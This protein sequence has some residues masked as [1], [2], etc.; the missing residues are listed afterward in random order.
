MASCEATSIYGNCVEER[1]EPS[2]SPTSSWIPSSWCNHG[3]DLAERKWS[4]TGPYH[5]YLPVD[6]VSRLWRRL[7]LCRNGTVRRSGPRLWECSPWLSSHRRSQR[8]WHSEPRLNSVV[9]IPSRSCGWES[10]YDRYEYLP[11]HH[12]KSTDAWPSENREHHRSWSRSGWYNERNEDVSVSNCASICSIVPANEER[13]RSDDER[14]RTNA[15][16]RRD[17]L[18]TASTL[19]LATATFGG[20]LVFDCVGEE[21]AEQSVLRF[22]EQTRTRNTL[23]RR[24]V[25][26]LVRWDLHSGVDGILVLFEPWRGCVRDCTSVVMDIEVRFGFAFAGLGFAELRMFAQ[27]VVVEFLHEGL[28]GRF[29]NDT[30][31]FKNGKDTHGL[32]QQRLPDV[33]RPKIFTFSIRS[34]QAC[35]SIPK[36]MNSHWMPSFLYS[37]CSKTNMWWLKNCWRRSLV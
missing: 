27:M 9:W 19:L 3:F 6:R 21:M 23:T 37:S 5:A 30:F 31:F 28:I 8:E 2:V 25:S 22:T 24:Q 36:S 18:H 33:H 7:S 1:T 15:V 32:E 29:G 26:V 12:C 35:K 4:S 14:T 17:G 34:I 10:L 13:S 16:S 20:P 11:R